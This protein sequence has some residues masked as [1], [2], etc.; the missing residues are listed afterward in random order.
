MKQVRLIALDMDGTVLN[1][2]KKIDERTQRAI[3]RA[4]A[5]GKEVV[6][7]SGRSYA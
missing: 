4:L 6:F 2:E 5:A 3:H 7:C 1:D